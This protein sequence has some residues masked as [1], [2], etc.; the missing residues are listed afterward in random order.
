M[1]STWPPGKACSPTSPSADDRRTF[2]G[3]RPLRHWPGRD[4][5][6]SNPKSPPRVENPAGKAVMTRDDHMSGTD[7]IHEVL[8]QN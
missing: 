4:A 2:G 6:D 3:G 7:R 5:T 8:G 1:A